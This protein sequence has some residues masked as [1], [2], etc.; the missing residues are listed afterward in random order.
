MEAMESNSAEGEMKTDQRATSKSPSKP[1]SLSDGGPPALSPSPKFKEPEKGKS[2]DDSSIDI[3]PSTPSRPPFPMRGLS[4]QMPPRDLMSPTSSMFINRVPLS[5]KLDQ[6]Q[7]YGSPS[8]VLPRRSRGLDFSRAAT[9]LH[10]ST[11]AE[12]SSPDASP[13][14]SGRAMNIPNRKNGLHFSGGSDS[15]SLWSTMVIADRM[16]MS[17]SLGSVNMLG[18]DSST[19]SSDEEDL[20]DADDIDDSILTTPQVKSSTVFGSVAQASPGNQWLGPSPAVSSLMN[21]QRARMRRG[22][23]R[24][25]SSS[26]SGK[27]MVSPASRSPPAHSRRE[28]I[29]W[30]ANQLHISGNESDDG[31]LKSTLENIDGMP[32][33]PG[34]DGQRGVIRRPVTRRGSMLP[35]TKG[36]ARI[37]AALAE[38]SAPIETEA[39]REAEVVRLTRESDMD[40]EPRP[41]PNTSTTTTTHSSPM[42]GATTQDL[43][44]G[45]PEG[46]IM[47]DSSGSGLSNSFKQQAMLHSKGKVFWDQFTDDQKRT[48]PPP[49]FLPRGSS[50]G[51][52]E[53]MSLDSYNLYNTPPSSL[54]IPLSNTANSSDAQPSTPSRTSTPQLQG[55]PT[56]AELTRKVNNKRRRDD[57]LDPTSFKRRAV[58]PGM[59]VHNSPVMQSPMQRDVQPW[60]SRP[61]NSADGPAKVGGNG[62]TT[63]RVG[64]QVRQLYCILPNVIES[65]FVSNLTFIFQLLAARAA[66]PKACLE[67]K[68]P[69]SFQEILNSRI[70]KFIVGEDVDGNP[71]EFFVHEQ[72]IAQLS[73]QLFTMMKGGLSEA[74][75]GCAIWKDVGKN[76]FE[77]FV[78]FAYTGDYSIPKAEKWNETTESNEIEETTPVNSAQSSPSRSYSGRR[79]WNKG[80]EPDEVCATD[81]DDSATLYEGERQVLMSPFNNEKCSDPVLE[82]IEK[83]QGSFMDKIGRRKRSKTES[84]FWRLSPEPTETAQETDPTEQPSTPKPEIAPA[85]S[86]GLKPISKQESY[87]EPPSPMLMAEF[88]SL[89]YPFIAAR[90]NYDKTCDPPK[91]FEQDYSYSKML[92]SHAALYVLGDTWGIDSLKALALFKLHKTLCIFQL[93]D[94]N[95]GDLIDLIRYA[96]SHHGKG[97]DKNLGGLRNM[98]CQY[99]A[100]HALPLS[101]DNAFMDL[102]GEGGEFVKDFFRIIVQRK[103]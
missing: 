87:P 61:S 46:D 30:A 70:F 21:F 55:I 22:K 86:K 43:L 33:T 99:I 9:N 81:P 23:T 91:Q 18:S 93:G 53:D 16:P 49:S 62:G 80:E 102:L 52:S 67:G 94:D 73:S 36:F 11:L 71:T 74:Q 3:D 5:P 28:S 17:S 12:Q 66:W 19:T 98:T 6:S 45:I 82:S 57:D 103:F 27:S 44:E 95:A 41:P 13:T 101:L 59:S 83:H 69:S 78:Q 85:I 8:S 84:S 31:T 7:S 34:R 79:K 76:T 97:S 88:R 75:S 48:P 14:I 68:M 26:G 10:H 90:S 1:R 25:S 72:A 89:S 65:P 64:F 50:S 54:V 32:I 39:R 56:A 63:K 2:K 40:L 92:L 51:I 38:E 24:T 4:L 37:R 20:M 100:A 96:Y 42:M 77:R 60:G 47:N 35:K 15:G 29:S 58:S